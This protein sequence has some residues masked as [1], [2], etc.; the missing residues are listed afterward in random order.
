MVRRILVFGQ[1]NNCLKTCSHNAVL[2][3]YVQHQKCSPRNA[4]SGSIRF[5]Q[6]F[7]GVRWQRGIKWECGGWKW[8]FLLRSFTVFRTFYIHGHTIA[9]TLYD[10][11]W[12][13]RY[14]KVVRLFHIREI[15]HWRILVLFWL[16][17]AA[18]AKRRVREE[19]QCRSW[20]FKGHR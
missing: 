12:P 19:S 6:I 5:M 1:N 3:I 8:L 14:F 18:L 7:A 16:V 20:S 9:V 2:R 4:V 11:R 10:C 13:W 17:A 15:R